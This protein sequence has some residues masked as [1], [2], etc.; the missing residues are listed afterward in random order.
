MCSNSNI[1]VIPV[2]HSLSFLSKNSIV[3][4]LNDHHFTVFMGIFPL[5]RIEKLLQGSHIFAMEF[6][7]LFLGRVG[8]LLTEYWATDCKS[9][10]C[11][12]LFAFSMVM[13]DA[14]PMSNNIAHTDYSNWS[15]VR[16]DSKGVLEKSSSQQNDG[17]HPQDF[18]QF[19]LNCSCL[20]PFTVWNL[21][22]D[23]NFSKRVYRDHW[24]TSN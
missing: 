3:A 16:K 7:N 21:V 5:V 1:I 23:V 19:V 9:H 24:C 10:V 4:S 17:C 13:N 18:L 6:V 2:I 11:L 8:N 20:C 14:Q 22:I 12:S 15:S